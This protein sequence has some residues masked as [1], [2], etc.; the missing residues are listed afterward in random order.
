MNR[1][2]KMNAN[3][4][5]PEMR[6]HYDK[7]CILTEG[8]DSISLSYLASAV[9]L[10]ENKVIR[11]LNF[12]ISNR[13]F[14]HGAYINYNSRT[15]V[16]RSSGQPKEEYGSQSQSGTGTGGR[17]SAAPPAYNNSALSLQK[18]SP[19]KWQ[20]G[21]LMAGGLV[22]L[23]SGIT[24]A[25]GEMDVLASANFTVFTLGSAWEFFQAAVLC[26]LGAFL[27][28]FRGSRKKRAKRFEKYI[29][30]IK[31]KAPVPLSELAMLTG[32][33][34][35]VVC[36][37]V[38]KMLDAGVLPSG[39]HIDFKSAQLCLTTAPPKNG[40]ENDGAHSSTAKSGKNQYYE[41]ICEIR[42]LNE[43]IL[44]VPVSDKIDRIE[45]LTAKIFRAVEDDP[46][47]EPNIKSFMS[48]YLPT[49]LKLLRTY[50]TFE[51]QGISGENI[52][53]AKRDI[54]NILDTLVDGFARQL[55]RLFEDDVI[56]ISTDIEV[57]ETMMKRDNLS[58]RSG[59][60]L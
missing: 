12:L 32:V 27:L 16:L 22:T 14:A 24:I 40:P 59:M 33:S 52:E 2:L 20:Q 35:N 31:G 26:G 58:G 41:I 36:R 56:D 18:L 57:L 51:K 10:P 28:I 38:Q 29:S 13:L 49:T 11:E 60:S 46:D 3:E 7:Y 53:S 19:K 42:K 54:E 43:D 55:D 8:Y 30:L 4:L 47:K 1:N 45:D 44:D 17:S 9:N 25:A 21:L 39:A 34:V 37:D 48:Y 50:A 15:L 5:Q 23:L 6:A